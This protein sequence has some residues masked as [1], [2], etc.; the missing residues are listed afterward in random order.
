MS[1][2]A[3]V[4]LLVRP[5]GAIIELLHDELDLTACLEVGRL[6]EV[7]LDAS[8]VQHASAFLKSID[9]KGFALDCKVQVAH[10]NGPLSLIFSGCRSGPGLLLI[11]ARE[12]LS[13][14][15]LIQEMAGIVNHYSVE[16]QTADKEF[17]PGI[18]LDWGA[19]LAAISHELRNPL[20]GILAASNYLLEDAAGLLNPEHIALLRSVESSCQAMFKVIDDLTVASAIE[21]GELRLALTPTDILELIKMNLSLNRLSAARK[22]IRIDLLPDVNLPPITLDPVHISRVVH[23]LLA[24][25]IRSSSPGG[26]IAVHVGSDGQ[27]AIISVHSEKSF[28]SADETHFLS[29]PHQGVAWSK[30]RPSDIIAFRMIDKIIECHAGALRVDCEAGKGLTFTLALPISVA[31]RVRSSRGQN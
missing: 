1:H 30:I 19:L 31:A 12:A 29:N 2:Q 16:R 24:K 11:G 6:F 17:G 14:G 27:Q 5:S 3:T 22:E 13:R 26:R 18:G 25:C 4:A 8:S 23:N 21:S 28:L 9:N 10:P 7:M 20:N 15:L